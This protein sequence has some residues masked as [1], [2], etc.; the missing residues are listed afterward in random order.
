MTHLKS[1][2]LPKD[3]MLGS[4]TSATQIEGG[5]K[6]NSWYEWCLW[7]NIEDGSSCLRAADHWN[8]YEED[9]ELLKKLN[10]KVYRM[11]IEW[12]RIEPRKGSFDKKA[13]AHYKAELELLKR[14][15]I[16]PLVTLHHFSNPVWFES[17]GG[18]EN[19]SCVK[20]FVRY[21]EY[22]V[23]EFGDL[24]SEYIT[25]NEPNVYAL[26]GYH[27]GIWPPGKMDMKLMYRVLKNMVISHVEAY[28]SIHKLRRDR[29]F[30]GTTMV[31][32]AYHLRVFA[33]YS[34]KP[35]DIL[36]ARIIEYM[37]QSA[38]ML[39]MSNGFLYAPIGAGFPYEIGCYSDFI[40][41]NYYSRSAVH[42]EGLRNDVM[43]DTPRNDLGWEIYPAGLYEICRKWH[44]KLKLPIWI[45]ENGT[46]DKSD[47]FRSR[48]IY[49]HLIEVLRLCNEGVPVERYYHW[50]LM[51]NFEWLHGESAPFGLVAVNFETQ[52]RSVKRSGEFYAEVCKSNGVTEQMIKKY[53]GG[54][55]DE[56]K[57]AD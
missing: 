26:N 47:T 13:I 3:F 46:C 10:H 5:D 34:K 9:I 39:S 37:F 56:G 42:L 12:S 48:Y 4:A 29:E 23:E 53:F 45:T 40:G 16:R 15:G 17:E 44:R 7:G 41:V 57:Q 18:F 27:Y 38:L 25:I 54:G 55:N 49:D 20:N 31:G 22:V 2:D 43:P 28:K 51:D 32:A 52:E 35:S 33:P 1:F 6:N 14:N 50:S 11:S 24:A 19:K 8:R 36:A 30:T 21:A